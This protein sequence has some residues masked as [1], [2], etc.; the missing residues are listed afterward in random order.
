MGS[1]IP[2]LMMADAGAAAGL[3]ASGGLSDIE[4]SSMETA[5]SMTTARRLT[6]PVP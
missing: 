4:A 5:D 6:A 3:D 1:S 2:G